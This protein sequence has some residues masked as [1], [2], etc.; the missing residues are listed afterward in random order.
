MSHLLLNL[1]IYIL[2]VLGSH[3]RVQAFSSR[4][5]RGL[6]SSCSAQVSHRGGF[7]CFGAGDQ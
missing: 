5:E 2:A 1:L 6:L 7:S 3:Y 4:G